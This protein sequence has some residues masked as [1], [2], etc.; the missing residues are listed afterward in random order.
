MLDLVGKRHWFFL[1][2]AILIIPGLISLAIP[3]RLKAGIEFSSGSTLTLRFEQPIQQ[4]DLR[5]EMAS[6]GHDEAIIQRT[7]GGD[8][9]VRIREIDRDEKVRLE[10]GLKG[11]FGPLITLDF[12]SVSPLVA[13]DIVRTAMIAVAV[14]AILMLVY[15]A[16]AFRKLPRSWRYG[17][18]AVI[19]LVYNSLLVTGV[20]S[21][22]GKLVGYQVDALFLTAI[23]TLVGYSI[24]DTVVVFD[25]T[26]ENLSKGVSRVYEVVVNRSLVETLP[27]SLNT[28]TCV[29][30]VLLVLL[31]FGG[32]TIQTFVLALLIGV[33]AGTYSS[34]F[35]ASMLMVAWENRD[36]SRWFRRERRQPS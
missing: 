24:N 17:V 29:I 5:Q 18:A 1:I 11:R 12:A 36:W 22:L 14:T 9:L 16:I 23:L 3:P 21:I 28:G 8:Y 26:R 2:S 31:L 7:G 10:E 25:R 33:V 34:I 4:A 35:N 6:L 32:I 15:I 19:A 20:F 30:L 27:R 13:A